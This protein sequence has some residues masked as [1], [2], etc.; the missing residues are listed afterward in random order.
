VV[1]GEWEKKEKVR[2]FAEARVAKTDG[3][4]W[5]KGSTFLGGGGGYRNT[6]FRERVPLTACCT[7]WISKEKPPGYRDR[8]T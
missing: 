5:G 2:R 8:S 3:R 7:R 6:Q 4:N 1:I